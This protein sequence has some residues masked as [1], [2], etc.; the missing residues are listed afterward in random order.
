MLWS[1]PSRD[2]Q[3]RARARGNVMVL[4]VASLALLVL[5]A[6]G[7]L[8]RTHSGR[9]TSI[10]HRDVRLA[11]NNAELIADMIADEIAQA[12]FVRPVDPLN[13]P[14]FDPLDPTCLASSNAARLQPWPDARRYSVDSAPD[15]PYN[16]APYHVVPWTNWPDARGN[17]AL[18][19]LLPPGDGNPLA[20]GFPG[21]VA[22]QVV[23]NPV[24]DPGF[25][26]HR[27]LADSEP[28]RWDIDGDGLADRYSHWR[29]LSNLSRPG[30][31]WRICRDISQVFLDPAPN[32]DGI[33][34]FANVVENLT[35]PVEQWLTVRPDTVELFS[36]LTDDAV[37]VNEVDFGQRWTLWTSPDLFDYLNIYDNSAAIPTNFYRLS[38]LNN[39]NEPLEDGEEYMDTFRRGTARWNVGRVLA[40]ADG[41]GHTDAFWHVVPSLTER[42]IR[43]I[44]AVRIVDNSSMLNFNAASR[45][46]RADNINYLRKTKG[47]TPA[48]LA[49]VGDIND[50]GYVCGANL[51][52]N[53]R[54]GFLDNPEHAEEYLGFLSPLYPAGYD[55]FG[56]ARVRWSFSRW[57]DHLAA[58]G[59]PWYMESLGLFNPSTDDPDE[60]LAAA[61]E[62][63]SYWQASGRSPLNPDLGLTPFNFGDELELRMYH[64]NNHSKIHTRFEATVLNRVLGGGEDFA[65][66]DP[67]NDWDLLH[68]DW[69]E[70]HETSESQ[71]QLRNRELMADLRSKLTAYNGA[72]NDLLP[73]WLRWRWRL[74]DDYQ[75]DTL[76]A[77]NF[78]AQAQRK[79]DLREDPS[80][81]PSNDADPLNDGEMNLAQRLPLVLLHAFTDGM[82]QDVGVGFRGGSYYGPYRTNAPAG[83]PEYEN[84]LNARRLAAGYAANILAYRDQDQDTFLDEAVPVPQL[85]D[86]PTD[87][88][89]RFSGLEM[90]P[91]LVEA[92]LG[93]VF[94][95]QAAQW[96]HEPGID[97]EPQVLTGH[98]VLCDGLA[99]STIVAVQIANP[100]DR[101]LTLIEYDANGNPVPGVGGGHVTKFELSVFG[102]TL[103]L[104]HLELQTPAPPLSSPG[105]NLYVLRPGESRT[106]FA[107]EDP[108]GAPFT[109]SDWVDV[110]ELNR[111]DPDDVDIT[112]FVDKNTWVDL[113][114]GYSGVLGLADAW[115]TDRAVYGIADEDEAI[116]LRHLVKQ[117]PGDVQPPV[118]VVVDRID[119]KPGLEGEPT[120]NY[121]KFGG[122]VVGFETLF[123]DQGFV[124]DGCEDELPPQQQ[125]QLAPY[126]RVRNFRNDATHV[127]QIASASRMWRPVDTTGT[128]MDNERNPRFVF[129]NR[130][131]KAKARWTYDA[132]TN[133]DPS[134]WFT[135]TSDDPYIPNFSRRQ[136][137]VPGLDNEFNFPMQMLQKDGD[138]EQVGE[139]LDVWLQAHE[140]AFAPGGGFTW[141]YDHTETTFSE[142]MRED[143]EIIDDLAALDRDRVITRVNRLRTDESMD[144]VGVPE[145]VGLNIYLDDPMHF[146]PR[147]P[148]GARVLDAFVCD[149]KGQLLDFVDPIGIDQA[150][151]DFWETQR[152]ENA[153]GFSGDLT[154]GLINVNTATREVLRSLPHWFRMVHEFNPPDLNPYVHLPEA[155]VQYRDRL[156]ARLDDQDVLPAYSDRGRAIVDDPVDP[157]D[158]IWKS[159]GWHVGMRSERGVASIGELALLDRAG[160]L[161]KIKIGDLI[162][163]DMSIALPADIR[164]NILYN[165]SFQI[166]Y[167]AV[168]ERRVYESEGGTL[169]ADPNY[170]SLFHE[171]VPPGSN[172]WVP[173]P[174]SARVSVDV[175]DA[176]VPNPGG[177]PNLQD[178]VSEDAEEANLLLAGASNMLTTRSDVFTVY[179][180]IRSF[181]QNP[182]TGA[183][184]ATDPEAIVEENRYV[185]LVDR[186]QVNRPSD[187]A[188]ILY[189]EQLPP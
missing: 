39:N 136:E 95:L 104:G 11:E 70:R 187:R 60:L 118:P 8:T 22:R 24:G 146:V 140:L 25:G 113:V 9:L 184:D 10:A 16:F 81:D 54:V 145:Q 63:L 71:D 162:Q 75:A 172:Q 101:L 4:V 108:G 128:I 143:F 66:N 30:N 17:L 99:S 84:G 62:R 164:N 50:N 180:R 48:D 42:G 160:K 127:V 88:S 82:R 26:D 120:A 72:R 175:M 80:F 109:R 123:T 116:E 27:W 173:V 15:F 138:F 110:L 65:D 56:E 169:P 38:N 122:R 77:D 36:G 155:V 107:M 100:Y 29:K 168:S 86:L 93:H 34:E 129:A 117:F 6:A 114:V 74:P 183:W 126:W 49:L 103:D 163:Y 151:V 185:M 97:G 21:N 18:A 132:V 28:L 181:R 61:W 134:Q 91:F 179:F 142:F 32:T 87:P 59:W 161:G 152:Y 139:L 20:I 44:V 46:V 43:Q 135:G 45:F 5:I 119:V 111:D 102:Q 58:I 52:C 89:R 156:G 174:N 159:P 148:A 105:P 67:S 76:E 78:L 177:A 137:D 90:Q 112:D 79:L 188:K 178:I 1:L 14:C 182:V 40:D 2:D 35:V 64:G 133:P 85:H 33:F 19:Q 83:T 144:L 189:L 51:T 166:D 115:S 73:P 53:L 171:E 157:T 131:V 176:G 149:G 23:G 92:F 31:G 153:N 7:F 12:L 186:S 154:P 141:N 165:S 69:V 106:Y 96:D 55:A 41:D 37:F 125:G 3:R 167:P 68:S 13:A 121:E 150:D 158:D 124:L 130:H 94:E 57:D 170:P 147:M 98:R 47:Q